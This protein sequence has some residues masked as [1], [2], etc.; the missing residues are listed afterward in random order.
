MVESQIDSLI[1]DHSF[2]HNFEF[3]T[4]NGECELTFNNYALRF[5]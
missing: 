5:F 2:S 3:I 4:S 1:H